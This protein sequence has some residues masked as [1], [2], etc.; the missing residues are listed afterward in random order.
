MR[1]PE[2]K[3]ANTTIRQN[4]KEDI[5]ISVALKGVLYWA[6]PNRM[7]SGGQYAQQRILMKIGPIGTVS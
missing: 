4:C 3:A 1:Q 6:K 7:V 5:K 2:G